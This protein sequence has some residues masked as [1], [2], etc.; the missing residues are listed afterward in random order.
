[1]KKT[2]IEL[3]LALV[4][5][6]VVSYGIYVLFSSHKMTDEEFWAQCISQT[7]KEDKAFLDKAYAREWEDYKAEMNREK[8]TTGKISYEGKK[9]SE[10]QK[11]VKGQKVT[12]KCAPI[13]DELLAEIDTTKL[14]YSGDAFENA[15]I[16]VPTPPSFNLQFKV[17][18]LGY[19]LRDRYLK[20]NRCVFNLFCPTPKPEDIIHELRVSYE[21][22]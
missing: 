12:Y 21:D 2:I 14:V 17:F 13:S 7:C 11:V 9:V 5:S 16:T 10:C 18:G 22:I 19:S 3:L 15:T 8:T 4:F 20:E 6:L 1:M